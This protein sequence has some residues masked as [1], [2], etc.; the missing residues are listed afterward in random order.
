MD[1]KPIIKWFWGNLSNFALLG[2]WGVSAGILPYLLSFNHGV[3]PV[4]YGLAAITGILSF[5]AFRAMWV[6][7]RIWTLEAKHR[8]IIG[9]DSSAFDPMASIYQN[10][11]LFLRD[12]VPPG[13]RFLQDRKFINC[14][15]IGPGNIVVALNKTNGQAAIFQNNFYNDVDFIQIVSEKNLLTQYISRAAI[16]MGASFS[17]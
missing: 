15:I 1:W 6:K 16:S 14:E 5:A 7:A 11:R 12:L 2:G 3:T 9:A 4:G 17:I 13:R 8:E 10:K